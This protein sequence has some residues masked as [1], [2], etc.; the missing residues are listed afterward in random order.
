MSGMGSSPNEEHIP[1]FGDTWPPQL[2]SQTANDD[3]AAVE[4]RMR[5]A[6]QHRNYYLYGI[7]EPPPRAFRPISQNSFQGEGL[8]PI[9]E[10][11]HEPPANAN[12]NNTAAENHSM[13]TSTGHNDSKL[14]KCCVIT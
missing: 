12:Q 8:L 4:R 2:S 1:H 13:R 10:L 14:R 6:Q 11:E 7:G 3:P 5:I 9:Q